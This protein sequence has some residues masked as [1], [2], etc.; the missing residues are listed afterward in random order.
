MA[1]A[2]QHASRKFPARTLIG[3]VL[4]SLVLA[5]IAGVFLAIQATSIAASTSG[6]TINIGHLLRM[7]ALQAGLTTILSLIIGLALAW[8]L[9]RVS[10]PGRGLMVSM[11]AAAIVTPGLV[12]AM[13]LLSVWGRAGWVNSWLDAIGIDFGVSIFGLHGIIAAHLVLDATFAARIL[14]ARLDAIP[15][16]ALKTGQSLNLS[17]LKR[18]L[19][20]DWPNIAGALPGLS[21]IIFLLAFTS[22]PIVLLLGGGPA[23]QTFEVAIYTEVRLSF[24][25]DN[26]VRLALVQLAVCAAIVLPAIS[27]APSIATGGSTATNNWREPTP[28][29]IL[30]ITIIAVCFTGFALPLLA[31]LTGGYGQGFIN[32]ITQPD[33]LIAL[34]TSL[35]IGTLSALVAL[36][37][38]LGLGMARATTPSRPLRIF[39]ELPGY[40][41]LMVPAIVLSLGFFLS[42]RALGLSTST[43]APIV[44]IIANALLALPF[45]LSTLAPALVATHQ[46][47]DKLARSLNLT[48]WQRWRAV[49]WPLLG[50]EIGI[51]LALGFCFSLGDLGVISLFGTE[52][53]A[54]LPWLMFR[55]LGAYRTNDAAAFA[56]ILLILSLTAFWALPALFRRLSNARI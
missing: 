6:P 37:L 43:A 47:Y 12:V 10:F 41:F 36:G 2:S 8:S 7:T 9:N 54:T 15:A 51:V 40:T 1:Q 48:G 19:V 45:A 17:P 34:T 11:F 24:D 13:G 35:V 26:A 29:R 28:I 32:A 20:L 21:A 33:F 5:L 30:Q 3:I 46:R 50:H 4:A 49:E 38:A 53:F 16:R 31:V 14:L 18:F 27:F 44:L 22:F 55:A 23:N 56:E 52:D 42:A 25:L 39:F